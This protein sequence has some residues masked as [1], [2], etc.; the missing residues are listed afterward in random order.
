MKGNPLLVAKEHAELEAAY[1]KGRAD[2]ML[3]AIARERDWLN[4]SIARIQ[5]RI[6]AN[7]EES[8]SFSAGKALGLIEGFMILQNLLERFGSKEEG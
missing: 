1:Q 8:D 2:G 7:G 3:N 4:D 5:N 6:E